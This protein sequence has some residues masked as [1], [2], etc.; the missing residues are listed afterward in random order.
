MSVRTPQWIIDLANS[1]QIHYQRG[2]VRMVK[3]ASVTTVL[4]RLWRNWR[5]NTSSGAEILGGDREA[6]NDRTRR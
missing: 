4:H 1:E 5:A 2:D 3:T 6:R